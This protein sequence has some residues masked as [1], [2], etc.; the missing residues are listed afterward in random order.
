[1]NDWTKLKLSA[2]FTL[3]VGSTIG[4]FLSILILTLF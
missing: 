1:M 4:Y 2:L 3:I